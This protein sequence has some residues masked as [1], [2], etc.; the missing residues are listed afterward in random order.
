MKISVVSG[1]FDPI[2]SGHIK[3]LN[4]AKEYGEILIVLLNSD[5]WLSGK[6]N[7]SF[8]Q[9]SERKLILE[10]LAMVDEVLGFKDDALG[11]CS[12][13]LEQIKKM[14]PKSEI[15]F[16]TEEIEIITTFLS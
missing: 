7:K 15:F 13:G 8:M 10:N 2:H 6:K 9:F 4:A 1:G 12:N 3:Y 16:A 14:F 11:S 5:E